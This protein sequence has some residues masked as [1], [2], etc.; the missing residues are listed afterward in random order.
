MMIM[1]KPHHYHSNQKGHFSWLKLHQKNLTKCFVWLFDLSSNQKL[2]HQT[3][4]FVM[5]DS[6]YYE[7]LYKPDL[8]DVTLRRYFFRKTFL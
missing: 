5:Y 4:L 3:M 7:Q 8:L 6:D 1:M 2:S